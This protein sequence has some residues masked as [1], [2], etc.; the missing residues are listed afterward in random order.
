MI[1]DER[2]PEDLLKEATLVVRGTAHSFRPELFG[3][4]PLSYSPVKCVLFDVD[5]LM[6]DTTRIYD[7]VNRIVV[8]GQGKKFDPEFHRTLKGM[9]WPENARKII[10]HYGLPDEIP[11]QRATEILR[12]NVTLFTISLYRGNSTQAYSRGRMNFWR[13]CSRT[14]SCCPA[15]RGWCGT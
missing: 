5:G 2:M 10:Q 8:E 15:S 14:A 7:E 12:Q 1:P 3:L 11:G 9:R 13:G 4:P 6:L